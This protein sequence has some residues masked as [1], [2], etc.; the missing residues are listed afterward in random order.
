[1]SKKDWKLLN[2]YLESGLSPDQVA[3]LKAELEWTKAAMEEGIRAAQ[4]GMLCEVCENQVPSAAWCLDSDFTCQK[5]DM[6]Y[7]LC[8][9]CEEGSN[10][11]WRG[12]Q[13]GETEYV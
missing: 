4:Q 3:A 12:P 6:V 5:C 11:A 8:K 9:T 2:A 7:C 13:D 1:M 10:W